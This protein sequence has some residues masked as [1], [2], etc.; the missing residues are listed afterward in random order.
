MPYRVTYIHTSQRHLRPIGVTATQ[1]IERVRVLSDLCPVRFISVEAEPLERDWAEVFPEDCIEA[2]TVSAAGMGG[3]KSLLLPG[4][5]TAREIADL[6]TATPP[7]ALD[8]LHCRSH[9][10]ALVGMQVSREMR[11][12]GRRA[13]MVY[14]ME[15]VAAEEARYAAS[16]AGEGGLKSRLRT[17][18]IHHIEQKGLRAADRVVAVSANMREFIAVEYGVPRNRVG[19]VQ[20]T[21]NRDIFFIDPD[22][23]AAAREEL[24]IAADATVVMYNGSFAP[25]QRPDLFMRLFGEVLTVNPDAILLIVSRQAERARELVAGAGL[26]EASTRLTSTEYDQMRRYLNAA[27]WGICLRDDDI[28]NRAASPTKVAEYLCC[29]TPVVVTPWVGDYADL[30]TTEDLGI[31]ID[32]QAPETEAVT[33]IAAQPPDE[34]KERCAEWAAANLTHQSALSTYRRIYEKLLDGA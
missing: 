19:V 28:V 10:S 17:S 31:V 1:V 18:F 33:A 11:A 6:L 30:A 3:Q 12:R 15:G 34:R 7:E 4:N 23:G 9:W 8:I 22:A 16:M 20:S 29:G 24:E 13:A 21:T 32:A 14:D 26:P 25:Y 2:R 27:D 5:R